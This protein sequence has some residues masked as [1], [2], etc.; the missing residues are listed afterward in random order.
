MQKLLRKQPTKFSGKS[1]K[2][3]TL[4]ASMTSKE[5]GG[6]YFVRQTASLTLITDERGKEDKIVFLTF[7]TFPSLTI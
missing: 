6:E 3:K 2:F 5:T 7:M 1:E 4:S